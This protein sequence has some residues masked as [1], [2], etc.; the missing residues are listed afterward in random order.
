MPVIK[1]VKVSWA[2]V[3]K[4][5]TQFEPAWEVRVHLTPDLAKSLQAEA[6]AM[7]KKGIKLTTEDNGE[8]TFRFRRKV[9]KPD[10]SE[11]KQP[12]VWDEHG[13]PFT[14]LIGNGSICDVQYAFVPYDNKFGTGLTSDF[15][16]I[17]VKKL[18]AYGEQD[19]EGLGGDVEVDSDSDGG[20]FDTASSKKSSNEYDDE[21]FDS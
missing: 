17:M 16:G 11:N 5:N 12:I 7:H 20:E 14:R 1:N 19:G 18:V 10:G 6:K 21:D 13:K 2:S 15:K 4:P 3:Q 8:L 9:S